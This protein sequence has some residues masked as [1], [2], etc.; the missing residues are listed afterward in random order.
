[1]ANSYEIRLADAFGVQLAVLDSFS[2]C[3]YARTVNDY[4]TLSLVLPPIYPISLFKE[5]GRISI[6]RSI[7]GA[8]AYLEMETIWFIRKITQ[9]SP[10][11]GEDTI[12]IEAYDALYLLTSRTI[13][14]ATD[15]FESSKTVFAD[16]MMKEIIDENV[17]ASATDTARDLSTY[18]SIQA[19]LSAAPSI[20]KEFAR[21]NYVLDLLQEIAQASKTAGTYLA[22]DIVAPTATTLEFRTYTQQRGTDHRFP[23]GSPPL[24]IGDVYNNLTNVEYT[25]DFTDEVTYVYAVGRGEVTATSSDTTRI[26]VSPFNRR[27]QSINTTNAA[28]VAAIIDEADAG[29]RAGRPRV[30]FSGQLIDTPQATYGLHYR[31]GDYVTASYRGQSIDCRIDSI[32]V[33]L[34]DGKETIATQLRSDD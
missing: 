23:G 31:F 10:D 22:F 18:L 13:A 25:N 3:V 12:E 17:G 21:R 34:A 29:V 28:T 7:N 32:Q 16:D 4:G 9:R 26:N 14:Y 5:D 19:N 11:S 20:S 6:Y 2:S 15:T 33:T 24:L 27:E 8:P 30:Y 1:M